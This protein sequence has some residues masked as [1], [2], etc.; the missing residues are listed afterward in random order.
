MIAVLFLALSFWTPPMQATPSDEPLLIPTG[1]F[2]R[3][4]NFSHTTVQAVQLDGRG[5]FWV[6]NRKGLWCYDGADAHRIPLGEQAVTHFVVD[7]EN[8]L[9]LS[10]ESG[11]LQIRP[12]LPGAETVLATKDVGKVDHLFASDGLVWVVRE[13]SVLQF[14][15]RG[16]TLVQ[17]QTYDLSPY[18]AAT[19]KRIHL[20]VDGAGR[21]WVMG[22]NQLIQI[23]TG[24][25]TVH[26]FP[27][28]HAPKGTALAAS[29]D[30]LWLVGREHLW[31]FK[32]ASAQWAQVMALPKTHVPAFVLVDPRDRLWLGDTPYLMRIDPFRRQATA[33][34]LAEPIGRK[35]RRVVR[36]AAMGADGA[37]WLGTGEGPRYLS[38]AAA[39]LQPVTG[40]KAEVLATHQ[41]SQRPETVPKFTKHL[42]ELEYPELKCGYLLDRGSLWHVHHETVTL[43]P[44][45]T[46][47]LPLFALA[48]ATPTAFW[49]LSRYG[50]H[51]F[52]A[53]SAVVLGFL[54]LPDDAAA[55]RELL[56]DADGGLI[57]YQDTWAAYLPATAPALADPPKPV[58]IA[59]NQRGRKPPAFVNVALP[60]YET[61]QTA[62]WAYRWDADS[63]W[64]PVTGN[65]IPFQKTWPGQYDLSL[66]TRYLKGPWR[67]FPQVGTIHIHAD[68]LIPPGWVSLWV[69][70]AFL[71][72]L[73]CYRRG[74]AAGA[75]N[76]N[77]PTPLPQQVASP[78]PPAPPPA[79]PADQP[80]R[81]L[82]VDDDPVNRQVIHA[83]LGERFRVVEAESGRDALDHL[84]DQTFDLVLL[85]IMM[86][87]L[88]GYETCAHLRE[89][90]TMEQLPVL[91][92]TARNQPEDLVRGFAMG[93][94]D[95]LIKPVSR[96]ELFARVHMHLTLKETNRL[97]EK[98]KAWLE[99]E[100]EMERLK[101]LNRESS[102]RLLH[103][104]MQPHFIQN[105][106]NSISFLCLSDP[107]QAVE[108][109]ERLSTLMRQSF[110]AVPREWWPL[111]EELKA[112]KAFGDIQRVR[113]PEKLR[114][115]F[116][117]PPGLGGQLLPPFL[118]QPLVENAVFYGLKETTEQV[119]VG[120][121][122]EEDGIYQQ[123]TVTNPGAPLRKPFAELISS[124]HALGNISERLALLFDSKLDYRYENGIHHIGFRFD[125]GR[126]KLEPPIPRFSP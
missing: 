47:N 15:A 119:V 29:K 123:V 96:D 11:E 118:I 62:E 111:E 18:L 106:L 108:T 8:R 121:S 79:S 125:P 94:N 90:H 25:L 50:L 56:R 104:Q 3:D 66:R 36:D 14:H 57:L 22:P 114:F 59:P 103:A 86:P 41:A 40:P 105:T 5:F 65:R 51:Q 88:S 75:K 80:A 26:A 17:A 126:P 113:F 35:H 37:L 52:D 19:P 46:P 43:N 99:T 95:Y 61:D 92:I 112:I 83:H 31:T 110:N 20:T 16:N 7:G 33:L 64:R 32:P 49:G 10:T 81:I 107:D 63:D 2:G 72:C 124:E 100:V 70:S 60:G 24:G 109:L 122:L 55:N 68:T 45:T 116:N 27:E 12:A 78:E 89:T 93:G 91:F 58:F 85:D 77:M 23:G 69:V 73:H 71:F 97:L 120:L 38:A 98:E 30:V 42:V 101:R 74:L 44:D 76:A 82:V 102:I 21:S 67:Q 39:M 13:T 34:T 28:E 84:N 1:S 48:P 87:G 4:R 115:D 117:I 6:L 9:W 53:A 54:P